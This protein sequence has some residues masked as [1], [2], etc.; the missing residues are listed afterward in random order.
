[1]LCAM[2]GQLERGMETHG[3]GQKMVAVDGAVCRGWAARTGMETHGLGQRMVAVDAAVGQR[4]LL[5]FS[6]AKA[7]QLIKKI[8]RPQGLEYEEGGAVDVA[9]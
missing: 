1:M 6:C 4:G 2:A 5:W 9:V 3:L 8:V 7:W